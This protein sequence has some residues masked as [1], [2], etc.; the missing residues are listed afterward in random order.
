MLVHILHINRNNFKQNV[1]VDWHKTNH[2]VGHIT[3]ASCGE[4]GRCQASEDDGSFVRFLFCFKSLT[5]K[6][7]KMVTVWAAEL[8]SNKLEDLS[9]LVN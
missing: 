8:D 7:I 9:N 2:L 4:E 6:Y 5:Y 3:H 1:V